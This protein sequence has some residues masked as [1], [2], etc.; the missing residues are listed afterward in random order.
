MSVPFNTDVPIAVTIIV[1]VVAMAS[2]AAIVV[3]LRRTMRLTGLT[4][5]VSAGVA[6]AIVVGAL[7]VGGSLTQPPAAVA[8]APPGRS[9]AQLVDPA[10]QI[11]LPT[12]GF[13]D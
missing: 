10:V 2:I 3:V 5:G 13:E 1:A 11:Q 12:L 8:D 9:S 4:V 6:I 7:F